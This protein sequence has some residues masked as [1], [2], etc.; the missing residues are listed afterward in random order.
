M[1]L[2]S[3]G[4][5]VRL[6]AKPPV[7]DVTLDKLTPVPDQYAVVNAAT[8]ACLWHPKLNASYEGLPLRIRGQKYDKGVG[9]RAP[10]YL[11]YDLK[12]EWERFV[13]QVG[14]ADNMLDQ[15]LGRNLARFPS[16]VFKVFVDGKLAAE[17]PVMRISQVPWRFDVPLPAGARFITLSVTDAGDRSPYDLGNWVES[18]FVVGPR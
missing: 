3:G 4:Y 8:H 2:E 1:S 7:P 9:M 16:V 14:V 15:E 11:R 17:S 18:G 10:G 5:W 12:P 6:P 13:A